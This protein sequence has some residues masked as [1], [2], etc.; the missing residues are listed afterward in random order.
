MQVLSIVDELPDIDNPRE[1][2]PE[3]SDT[4]HLSSII[5]D[6]LKTLDRKRFGGPL[7]P[8]LIEIGWAFEHA[9]S[10]GLL[11][12]FKYQGPGHTFHP[13]EFRVDGV[14]M[15]PDLVTVE[16]EPDPI[17]AIITDVLRVEELKFTRMS[18]RQPITDPKFWHYIVQLKAYARALGTLDARLR[19]LFING[20]Y[21]RDDNDPE[22]GPVYR[23]FTL[24][25]SPYELEENWQMLL[26][27][28]V[29]RGW[30]LPL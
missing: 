25:F 16:P 13:G 21:S 24:R 14:S 3:R 19:V 10:R 4:L 11:G 7:N 23:V 28:A 1:G 6:M 15:S 27:H 22:G 17:T 12:V 9:L 30:L 18:C 26:N 8:V 2:Q 5:K 29:R 20:N